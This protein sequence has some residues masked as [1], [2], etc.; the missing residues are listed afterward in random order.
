M[1]FIS[2][3]VFHAIC[4]IWELEPSTL[5]AICSIWGL[6]P[7]TLPAI[8][9][10]WELEPSTLQA[11]CSIWELQPSILQ[12]LGVGTFQFCMILAF[13]C[14][15][16]ELDFHVAGY[17]QVV[18]GCWLLSVIWLWVL[19]CFVIFVEAVVVVVDVVFIVVVTVVVVIVVSV[20]VAIVVTLAVGEA[21][22]PVKFCKTNK[23]ENVRNYQNQKQRN[24]EKSLRSICYIFIILQHQFVLW[25]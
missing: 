1:F 16:L 25:R 2:V 6:E 3:P 5:P 20:V 12:H 18:V 14:N 8:C 24:K 9:S 11:I 22:K 7:S 23:K 13:V 17:L 4:S 15:N 19:V 21:K 10:I